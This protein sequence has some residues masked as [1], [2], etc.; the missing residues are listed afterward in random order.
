MEKNRAKPET[1]K[2]R[3][4]QQWQQIR[5]SSPHSYYLSRNQA[6][7]FQDRLQLGQSFYDKE[8][9]HDDDIK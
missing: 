4:F 2:P 1:R 5:R 3:S 9:A 8:A 7:V 6:K